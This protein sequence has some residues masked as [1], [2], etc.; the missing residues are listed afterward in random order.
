MAI[1]M[2]PSGLPFTFVKQ[3]SIDGYHVLNGGHHDD[4]WLIT[5]TNQSLK[6]HFAQIADG[7]LGYSREMSNLTY[8]QIID[9]LKILAQEAAKTGAQE[10][11][12]ELIKVVA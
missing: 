4:D 5:G 6:D 9:E 3:G 7:G 10:G 8:S 2:T 11:A 12:K 1:L